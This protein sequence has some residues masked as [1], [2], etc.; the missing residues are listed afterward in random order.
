MSKKRP[1][2]QQ[3]IY[4]GKGKNDF[5]HTW[6]IRFNHWKRGFYRIRIALET[7]NVAFTEY[8]SDCV[9]CHVTYVTKYDVMRK[10]DWCVTLWMIIVMNRWWMES[11][12]MMMMMMMMVI[13]LWKSKFRYLFIGTLLYIIFS[14]Y[15]QLF[16]KIF[17]NTARGIFAKAPYMR[18]KDQFSHHTLNTFPSSIFYLTH[19][20]NQHLLFTTS[21]PKM[22]A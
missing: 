6:N 2:L 16:F 1:L 3:K 21:S 9:T 11:M 18:K 15:Q 14:P 19:Y 20:N 4:R 13:Q 7:W 22:N 5:A 8:G 17:L 10:C 12:V